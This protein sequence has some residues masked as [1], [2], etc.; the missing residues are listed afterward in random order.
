MS[1]FDSTGYLLIFLICITSVAV[2]ETVKICDDYFPYPA[3]LR[4]ISMTCQSFSVIIVVGWKSVMACQNKDK[5]DAIEPIL[6]ENMDTMENN[7]NNCVLKSTKGSWKRFFIITF[8]SCIIVNAA[9]IFNFYSI[10][11]V[12]APTATSLNGFRCVFVLILSVI[13]LNESL[14]LWKVSAIVVSLLGVSCYVYYSKTNK[15]NNDN[16]DDKDTLMGIILCIISNL[17]YSFNDILAKQVSQSYAHTFMGGILFT[18][19]QGIFSTFIFWWTLY[20]PKNMI[21]DIKNHEYNTF[22]S[23]LKYTLL[24]GLSLSLCNII[25]FIT[26]AYK[27][28]IFVNVGILLSIPLAY[29][30]DLFIHAYKPAILC[31]FG[32]VL[33]ILSFLMLEI[34]KPPK[35]LKLCSKSLISNNENEQNISTQ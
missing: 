11:G 8:C 17:L 7:D 13:I 1:S 19:F 15:N 28:P 21:H 24:V 2:T 32:A 4:Y 29:I 12:S 16:S 14:T 34:I 31:I 22:S 30:I 27:S 10:G 23:D 18:S 25:S 33:L 3:I 20:F 5:S 35:Y 6:P 9:G 26:M